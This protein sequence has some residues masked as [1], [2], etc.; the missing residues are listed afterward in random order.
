VSRA[1]AEEI[2][3]MASGDDILREFLAESRENLERAEREL[4]TLERDPSGAGAAL[5]P[6]FRTL[7][8]IKGTAGFFGFARLAELTHL[9]EDLLS[10]LRDGVAPFDADA[11]AALLD[12]V[13]AVRRMFDS[14]EREHDEGEGDD[15]ALRAQLLSLQAPRPGRLGDLLVQRGVA[16]RE[17]VHAALE[18]QRRGDSR[19]L[20]QIL[21]DEGVSDAAS[22]GAVLHAQARAQ[23]AADASIRVDVAVFEALAGLGDTLADTGA[24]LAR[25]AES[26]G[27]RDLSRACRRLDAVTQAMHAQLVHARMQPLDGLFGQ[28]PRLVR[29]LARSCGKKVRLELSGGETNV[30]RDLAA[31][32]KDP[33]THLLRNAVDHGIELAATRAA[34][35]KPLEGTLRVEAFFRN[36]C[37]HVEVADDGAGIDPRRV[38]AAAVERGIIAAGAAARMSGRQLIDL[39][40]V[41]GF[42][43]AGAVTHVSGR[44]VGMDVVKS[45]VQRMGGTI[46]VSS[47]LGRG[48]RLSIRIPTRAPR[49]A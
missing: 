18:A 5:P 22:I 9:A 1:R 11:S 36:R 49:A 45:S 34:A 19:K 4:V 44:G 43:T 39:I 2:H 12:V 41:P 23:R 10:K 46:D 16:R 30:D 20:G 8:T 21:V 13:D 27:R 32:I 17:D 42:S 35:G 48:T 6:L 28:L 15:R 24:Q 47:R 40:F 14:I 31:A 3:E 37:L 33:L 25:I 7:H 29:D 26:L 38:R